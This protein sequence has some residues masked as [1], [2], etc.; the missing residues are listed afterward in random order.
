M[1]G[2]RAI[3][4]PVRREILELLHASPLPAGRI[5][6]RFPI[7]RP[8]ISKHL[9]ILTECGVVEAELTGRQRIYRLR[10]E[11]LAEVAI[12]LNRLLGPSLPSRLDA[13]ATEVARARRDRRTAAPNTKEQSA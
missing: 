9:R 2:A 4:D 12:Y 10:T 6:E 1:D 3:A 13:L 7:S 5:A 8:A 11:P